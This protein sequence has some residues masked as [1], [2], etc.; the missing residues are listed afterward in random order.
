MPDMNVRTPYSSLIDVI[1]RTAVV[2]ACQCI[3]LSTK[4][5]D[6]ELV[7]SEMI[8]QRTKDQLLRIFTGRHL[9]LTLN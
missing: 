9:T 3:V 2:V 8:C 6:R 7:V 5:L 1:V 4:R